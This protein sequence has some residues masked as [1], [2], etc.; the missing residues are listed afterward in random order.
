MS[1][2]ERTRPYKFKWKHPLMMG[3][4]RT[5]SFETK[6]ARDDMAERYRQNGCEIKCWDF[7][8]QRTK[9]RSA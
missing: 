9:K 5:R 7:A 3:W 8:Q 6:E 4:A 1:R 2:G